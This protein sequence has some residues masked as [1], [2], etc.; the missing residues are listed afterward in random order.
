M[1]CLTNIP[2]SSIEEDCINNLTLTDS[3]VPTN[4]RIYLLLLLFCLLATGRVS[5]GLHLLPTLHQFAMRLCT[6]VTGVLINLGLLGKR[7]KEK[8]DRI[9]RGRERERERGRE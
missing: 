9:W 8:D 5:D 3:P 6:V 1:S 7:R 2:I 4:I